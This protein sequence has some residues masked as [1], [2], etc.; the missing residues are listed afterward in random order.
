[1]DEMSELWL[2]RRLLGL[3]KLLEKIEERVGH[4]FLLDGAIK[5]FKLGGD[6]VIGVRHAPWPAHHTGTALIFRDVTHKQLHS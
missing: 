4:G 6:L 5:S 1:M 3:V 2:A